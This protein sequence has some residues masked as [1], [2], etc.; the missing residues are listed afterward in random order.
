MNKKKKKNICLVTN[1]YPTRDN[2]Y[3]GLFFKEQAFVLADYYNFVVVH[4][5]EIISKRPFIKNKIKLVNK[6]KNTIEYDIVVRLPLTC[7][8]GDF[9]SVV[10]HKL[11][12]EL[13][14]DGVGRYFSKR[15]KEFSRKTIVKC[16]KKNIKQ[17]IDCFYCVDAQTE[18]F[19]LQCLS[20]YY[21]KPYIVSEHAP[22]PWPGAVLSDVNKIAI[23]KANLFMAISNDKIRQLMLLNIK[24]PKT[25]YIGNLIE[26]NKFQLK[27]N[28][29]KSVKTFLIVA[30]HS[31]YKNYDLFIKVMNRLTEI[32]EIPFKV[33]IVGYG[34]NKGYSKNVDEFERKIA[35][36]KFFEYVELIPE[37]PHDSINE[38]YAKA[39]AFVLTSIQEG[40][41]VSAI[42][43]ACCGLPIFSTRCGGVEDYV[44]DDIGRI[45]AVSDYEGMAEG[46]K[47]Y[48]EGVLC[49]DTKVIREKV[50]GIFGTAAFIRNARNAFDGVMNNG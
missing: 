29:D 1:W 28:R 40:Q 7:I 48:L 21:N 33:L 9:L 12:P 27:Q 2:P 14:I 6:E 45:Y 19:H 49:F 37:V 16:F 46:L 30:S 23:E 17:R 41:P 22:V 32:T 8:I 4:Y 10:S 15:R 43:A 13:N 50:V 44:D 26:E 38:I 31:Y 47:D 3:N 18:A 20:D 42:E 25:V 5:K 39:D 24:L 35:F 11:H 34:A 36:S